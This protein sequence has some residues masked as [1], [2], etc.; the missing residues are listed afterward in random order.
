MIKRKLLKGEQNKKVFLHAALFNRVPLKNAEN[1]SILSNKSM[2]EP[3]CE[4]HANKKGKYIV[5]SD[6]LEED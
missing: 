1:S 6:E 4:N 5:V 3:S 2:N